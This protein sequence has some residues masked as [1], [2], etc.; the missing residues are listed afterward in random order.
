MIII[1]L[2]FILIIG[3]VNKNSFIIKFKIINFQMQKGVLK[4]FINL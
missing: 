2:Y 1:A 3:F 4:D